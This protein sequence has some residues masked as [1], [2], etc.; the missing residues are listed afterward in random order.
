MATPI[1]EEELSLGVLYGT[2]G[3]PEFSTDISINSAGFEQSNSLW[4]NARGS[5]QLGNKTLNK[6]EANYL[7]NFYRSK[8]G[9]GVGFLFKDFSDYQLTDEVIGVG[10]AAT[11][12]FQVTKKYSALSVVIET[13][14]ITRVVGSTLNVKLNGVTTVAYAINTTTGL[15]T[16][17]SPPASG[18]V[19][20]VTCEFRVPVR[21]NTDKLSINFLGYDDGSKEAFFDVGDL[22]IVEVR[23]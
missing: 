14:K 2:I 8:K 13:R 3:G 4:S 1:H 18:A 5:W 6:T 7:A 20:T 10:N 19:I 12:S 23:E 22:T 16:F 11:F 21:F 17:D 9:K 15:I